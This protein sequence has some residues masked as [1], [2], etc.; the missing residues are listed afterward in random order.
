MTENIFQKRKVI[1]MVLFFFSENTF[2]GKVFHQKGEND[3]L[4]HFWAEVIFLQNY[5]KF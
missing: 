4:P 5:L 2:Q 1:I 3:D